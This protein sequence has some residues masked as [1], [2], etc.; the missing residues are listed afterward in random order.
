[1]GKRI[2]HVTIPLTGYAQGTVIAESEEEA[3]NIFA[4]ECTGN[5]IDW[6]IDADRG[7][8]VGGEEIEEKDDEQE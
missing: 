8:A 2:Y 5:D 6:N 3:I 7:D 1:M 4:E